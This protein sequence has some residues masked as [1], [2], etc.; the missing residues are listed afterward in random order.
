[1]ESAKR[2][3]VDVDAKADIA[4]P[5]PHPPRNPRT[6]TSLAF[7]AVFLTAI[8]FYFSPAIEATPFRIGR[9]DIQS[10][11]TKLLRDS[12]ELRFWKQ[13]TLPYCKACCANIANESPSG[14]KP[15]PLDVFQVYTPPKVEGRFRAGRPEEQAELMTALGEEPKECTQTLMVHT[16]GWSYGQPFVGMG[17]VE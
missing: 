6:M 16:F 14:A 7:L 15:V 4:S 9:I 5:P 17:T 11:Q 12:C 1:M 13:K 10:A 2:A 8:A 3:S